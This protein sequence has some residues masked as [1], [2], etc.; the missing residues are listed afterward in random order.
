VT[1][2]T[3]GGLC[4]DSLALLSLLAAI[5]DRCH[6]VLREAEVTPE[7]FGTAGRVPAFVA[8]RLG[9]ESAPRPA[10]RIAARTV[11]SSVRRAWSSG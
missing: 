9:G 8:R 6:L 4:L 1:P 7:N 5:E 2:L 11:F 3:D 10:V